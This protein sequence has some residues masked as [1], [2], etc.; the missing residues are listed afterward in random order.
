MPPP[1]RDLYRSANGDRWSVVRDDGKVETE[2]GGFGGI[3]G[4]AIGICQTTQLM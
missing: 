1:T 2:A 3:S 4:Q